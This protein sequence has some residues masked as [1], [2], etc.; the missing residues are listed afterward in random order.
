MQLSQ[1][2]FDLLERKSFLIVQVQRNSN[3]YFMD[4]PNKRKMRKA[5][6]ECSI[7]VI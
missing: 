6:D 5:V 3:N 4:I 7:K 1:E 2:I